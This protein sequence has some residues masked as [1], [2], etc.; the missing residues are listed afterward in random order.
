MP[1][2]DQRITAASSIALASSVAFNSVPRSRVSAARRSRS[3]NAPTPS[4][5]NLALVP[6][7]FAPRTDVPATPSVSNSTKSHR[8]N[9]AL[10]L[11][12]LVVPL[13]ALPAPHPPFH[14]GVVL[15]I[16]GVFAG[17][18]PA[19]GQLVLNVVGFLSL[20]GDLFSR[21]ETQPIGIACIRTEAA[22]QTLAEKQPDVGGALRRC[23]C[24]LVTWGRACHDHQQ[25]LL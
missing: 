4:T 17:Q 16:F 18:R 14:A 23:L 6:S 7:D 8:P 13:R 1:R 25:D 21:F 9:A 15:V 11:R 3:R 24:E 20:P 19:I 22:E 10:L 2:V 5:L 12:I